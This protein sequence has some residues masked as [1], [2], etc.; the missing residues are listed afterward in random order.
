MAL[1]VCPEC[2]EQVSSR[3]KRCPHC[4]FAKRRPV[5]TIGKWFFGILLGIIAGL[6][7]I[8]LLAG[9]LSH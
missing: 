5:T 3:A 6:F 4:G 7:V 8:G 1:V 9:L 2:N